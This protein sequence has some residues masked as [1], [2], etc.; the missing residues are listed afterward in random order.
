MMFGIAIEMETEEVVI[1]GVQK[2]LLVHHHISLKI[3]CTRIPTTLAYNQEWNIQLLLTS[4]QISIA[5]DL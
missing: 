5:K 2:P 4:Q 1:F 3:S